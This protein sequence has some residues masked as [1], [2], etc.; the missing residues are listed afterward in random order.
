MKLNAESPNTNENPNLILERN[1]E[2]EFTLGVKEKKN[3]R[4]QDADIQIP[5]R[6]MGILNLTL[7]ANFLF[8]TQLIRTQIL[9]SRM[10][11]ITNFKKHTN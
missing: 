5:P 10:E 4:G 8:F 2:K 1:R 11:P 6:A 9:M 7:K 3:A